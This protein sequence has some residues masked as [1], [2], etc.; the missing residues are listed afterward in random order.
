MMQGYKN[1]YSEIKRITVH[2]TSKANALA[3]QKL[4]E[5]GEGGSPEVHYLKL[6]LLCLN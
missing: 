5:A 1:A 2:N 4:R 6:V 3:T